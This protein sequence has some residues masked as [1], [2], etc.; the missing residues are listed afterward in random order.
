MNSFLLISC[1]AVLSCGI[2]GIICIIFFNKKLKNSK[3]AGFLKK[4][5][6]NFFLEIISYW[7]L[8]A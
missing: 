2:Q 7:R 1:L 8:T 3:G 6:K 5:F 4:K